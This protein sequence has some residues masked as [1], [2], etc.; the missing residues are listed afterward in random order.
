VKRT[1]LYDYHVQHGKM[2]EFAGY[3]MPLWYTSIIEE[4]LAVRNNTGIFDVS[5]MG[6]I[7]VKGREAGALTEA[8]VPTRSSSQPVGRS[9]YTLLL[10]SRGG[11][12]DDLIIIK[13]AEDDYLFVVNAANKTKDLEQM[14]RLSRQYN[15]LLDD[16]TDTTTMIAIQGPAASLALQD[17]TAQRLTEIKRFNHVLSK[18]GGSSATITRTGY[19][20]EDGFEIILYD[21]GIE[22]NALAMSV[23]NDLANKTRPCG[24]GARDS[25]RIEAGLPLYGSDIDDSTNP[26]EADLSWVISREKT[27]YVGGEVLANLLNIQ[28]R[29]LRRGVLLQDKIPRHGFS[30]NNEV[31]E[32]IG[33]VTSGT[34]SPILKKGIALVYVNTPYSTI[35]QPVRVV[36][37]DAEVG[38]VIIKPPF[39]DV[40]SYGWKREVA[41]S[42]PSSPQ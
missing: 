39:Y 3:D 26:I 7:T 4:H 36:V 40:K 2:A 38:A 11:I 16:I 9:F 12:V 20:G 10:N 31:G 33:H 28:P 13:K 5:H 25:L 19:T 42:I 18:I 37:R 30:V 8:L 41:T 24:L 34:Y 35:G 23:W 27:G 14:E 15:V 6:R 29:K 21:S 17:F 32:N 1:P 22:N